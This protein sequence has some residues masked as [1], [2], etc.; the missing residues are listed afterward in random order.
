MDIG[1]H[2]FEKKVKDSSH[3]TPAN[4]FVHLPRFLFFRLSFWEIKQHRYHF[5]TSSSRNH[6]QFSA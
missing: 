3:S 1:W 6:Y 4:L 5:S 2:C